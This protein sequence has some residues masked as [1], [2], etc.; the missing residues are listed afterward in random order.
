MDERLRFLGKLLDG[1]SMT[2]VCREF[3]ISGRRGTRSST[4]TRRAG[5]RRRANRSRRPVRLANQPAPQLE[6]MIVRLKREK[7]HRGARKIRELP[8]RAMR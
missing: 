8:A 1:E 2:D 7:P 5:S 3:G 4:R 6:S